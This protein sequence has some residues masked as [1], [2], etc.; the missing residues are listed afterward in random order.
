VAILMNID[1][2]W[3]T[4]RRYINMEAMS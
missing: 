3:Q 2:E 4:G 1:E